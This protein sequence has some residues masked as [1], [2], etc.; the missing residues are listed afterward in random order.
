MHLKDHDR[1]ILSIKFS[2]G[3]FQIIDVLPSYKLKIENILKNGI[4][5]PE[6]SPLEKYN[7]D[8]SDG[9]GFLVK[10]AGLYQDFFGF[11]C[12]LEKTW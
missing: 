9:A 3:E 4:R 8:S 10:I 1:M 7:G 12:K 6:G 5:Y 2:D 11:S